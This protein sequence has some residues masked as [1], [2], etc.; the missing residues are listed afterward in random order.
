MKITQEA[1]DHLW[2]TSTG[3]QE[4]MFDAAT[5]SPYEHVFPNGY[6]KYG[7]YFP[8]Q[9]QSG[10]RKYLKQPSPYMK[11][12]ILKVIPAPWAYS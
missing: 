10:W 12:P 8:D 7:E 5:G 11:F 9:D 4:K 2:E 3:T 6:N 1:W